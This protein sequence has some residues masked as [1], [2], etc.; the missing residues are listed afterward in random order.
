RVA[1][2]GRTG[3]A[4]SFVTPEEVPFLLDLHLFLGRPLT[5]SPYGAVPPAALHFE[6]EALDLWLK[7]DAELEAMVKVVGNA[8]KKYLR[9]RPRPSIESVKRARKM[10]P[11]DIHPE[12]VKEAPEWDT[13]QVRVLRVPSGSRKPRSGIRCRFAIDFE[14]YLTFH[15]F[16][17]VKLVQNGEVEVDCKAFR[18]RISSSREI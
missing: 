10:P 3:A 16:P 5:A 18:L 17:E 7:E 9:S 2:A 6:R 12:W 15:S 11:P 4:F 8:M 13:L 1:R 14:F